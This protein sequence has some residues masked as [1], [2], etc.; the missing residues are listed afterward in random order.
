MPQSSKKKLEAEAD[1]TYGNPY[2]IRNHTETSGADLRS[3][4]SIYLDID[5]EMEFSSAWHHLDRNLYAYWYW[6]T[7]GN[8]IP[9]VLPQ[10]I[11]ITYKSKT[12]PASGGLNL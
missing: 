9:Q 11:L 7:N 4:F 1:F 12:I 5:S 8:V 3:L 10:A 2:W 6:N